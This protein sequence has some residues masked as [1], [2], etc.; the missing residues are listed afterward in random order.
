MSQ[1]YYSVNEE[2]EVTLVVKVRLK[3]ISNYFHMSETQIEDNIEDAKLNMKEHLLNKIC[4]EFTGVEDL[5]YGVDYWNFE[6]EL[7]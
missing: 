3:S 2:F 7:I 1:Q 5:S 4:N 6:V